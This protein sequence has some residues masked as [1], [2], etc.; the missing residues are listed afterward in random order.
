MLA[1]ALDEVEDATP[2]VIAGVGV[3]GEAAVEEAVWR[4]RVH[5]QLGLD[6]GASAMAAVP[7][8]RTLSCTRLTAPL[9]LAG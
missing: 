9:P 5:V 7:C 8:F 1:V 3:L 6:T 4:V 2:C